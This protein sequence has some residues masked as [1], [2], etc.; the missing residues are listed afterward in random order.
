MATELLEGGRRTRGSHTVLNDE[1]R[2]RNR[3][4]VPPQT[5]LVSE[6]MPYVQ[7]EEPITPLQTAGD[8]EPSR[9]IEYSLRS[10]LASFTELASES[11]R[12]IRMTAS[13]E[14]KAAHMDP[15]AA[16]NGRRIRLIEKKHREGL[17]AKETAE[18]A[19]L[20]REVS[21]HIRN[22][23]P[24]STEVLDDLA[25][26]IEKLKKKAEAQRGKKA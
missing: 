22:I 9:R 20:K 1:F 12:R 10:A 19:R 26:R 7:E 15:W 16:K 17:N 5:F 13:P 14:A 21:E 3:A 23:D 25:V 8:S 2:L 18:L 24:R 11:P 4:G 6:T